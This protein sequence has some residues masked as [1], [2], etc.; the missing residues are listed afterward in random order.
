MHDGV[1]IKDLIR[2]YKNWI[3]SGD[4]IDHVTYFA[5]FQF[6]PLRLNAERTQ[7]TMKSEIERFYSVLLTNV[8]RRPKRP[9]DFVRLI[10]LP[11]RPVGKRKSTYRLNDVRPNDGLHFHAFIR[12]PIQSRLRCGLDTHVREHEGRYIGSQRKISKIDIRPIT[13][14]RGSLV[15]YTFKNIKRRT[16]SLDEVLIL[17]KSGSEM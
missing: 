4:D 7:E 5:T 1:Y 15:D 17:P 13:D 9:E 16:V 6:H 14:L 11:D 2:G 10:A 3:T 8:V 12:L